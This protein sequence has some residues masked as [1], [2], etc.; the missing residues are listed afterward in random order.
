MTQVQRLE[1]VVGGAVPDGV[2]FFPDL[3]TWYQASRL[4]L[5]NEQ[6]FLPGQYIP[7]EDPIHRVPS[8]L[9]GPLSRLSY[10]D[11]YREFGWG[12]PAHI[13]DWF[14]E[15]FD[16]EA[17]RSVLTE[18]RHRTVRLSCP[19]GE[20][21]RT[22]KLDAEGTWSEYGHLV[23]T[24]G[25]LDIVRSL[26]EHTRWQPHPERVERFLR[27]TEGFGACDLVVFRSPFG[28]LVHEY[29]GF[30]NLVYALED[31][32]KTILDFMEFQAEYDLRFIELAATMPGTVVIIS[33]HAD[34]N[35]ISPPWYRRFCMPFYREACSI[36]HRA[37]K[38]VSTHLDGNIRDSFPSSPTR[39]STSSM[40]APPPPCSTTRSRSSPPPRAEGPLRKAR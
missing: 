14:D 35:L 30:E 11:F 20:L 12:L 15:A 21:Y 17:R 5:G 6:P 25:D 4:G 1:A 29:L 23:K 19:A 2:P 37:G 28:K 38:L 8:L 40:A 18:G 34:E 26:V 10:V 3:S 24:H 16:G 7:D 33:D 13:Y 31:D 27:E 32:E 39:A 22:Y 9:A 36:L